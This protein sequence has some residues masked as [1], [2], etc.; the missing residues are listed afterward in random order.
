MPCIMTFW[1]QIGL[2]S[3]PHSSELTYFALFDFII[4][5]GLKYYCYLALQPLYRVC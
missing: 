2:I 5:L 1:L 3:V 4:P